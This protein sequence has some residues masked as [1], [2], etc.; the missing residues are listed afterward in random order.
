[1]AKWCIYASVNWI[2]LANSLSPVQCQAI[3]RTNDGILLIGPL[4]TNFSEILIKIYTFLLKK[5]IWK[6]HLENMSITCFLQDLLQVFLIWV[7]FSKELFTGFCV[8]RWLACP[9]SVFPI[10]SF[11]CRFAVYPLF[12]AP[13]A[14]IEK[15][16]KTS[17]FSQENCLEI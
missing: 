14:L 5:C 10:I 16:R 7:Q 8:V 3:I 11:L 1:M 4:R 17:E 15:E 12:L 2:I 13:F 9:S 6:C